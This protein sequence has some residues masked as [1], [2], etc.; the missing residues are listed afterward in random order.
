[1]AGDAAFIDP[2][3]ILLAEFMGP[4]GLMAYRL[5]KGIRVH[6]G[7][8]LARESSTQAPFFARRFCV[9]LPNVTPVTHLILRA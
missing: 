4:L 7:W 2:G 6:M 9:K 5:A 1:M 3:E 8:E